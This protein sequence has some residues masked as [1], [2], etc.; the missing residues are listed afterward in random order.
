[1][2][3]T[4]YTAY[5]KA[6]LSAQE[7][8][9]G[10][11]TEISEEWFVRV[12]FGDE[13]DKALAATGL[14]ARNA[15]HPTYD[16]L[17]VATRVPTREDNGII[18]SFEIKY[19]IINVDADTYRLIH[20]EYGTHELQEDLVRNLGTGKV[21]KDA[22]GKP[23][24]Q[25]MQVSK[26]YPFI[27]ITKKQGNVDR[28]TVITTSGSINNAKVTVAG[29][30]IPKWCGKIR[31]QAVEQEN[32]PTYNWEISYEVL[33]R[34]QYLTNYVDFAD[35]LQTPAAPGNE[36]G[37]MEGIVNQGFYKYVTGGTGLA[38][39]TEQVEKAD[40]S[41][42]ERP[43]A[44]PA[45]LDENGEQLAEGADPMSILLQIHPD[46]NWSGLGLNEV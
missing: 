23:F 4:L 1:M 36:I 24:S 40:G 9:D 22:N 2:G 39:I 37:W 6:Q 32:E 15:V 33:V 8:P 7:D 21:L 43:S 17:R 5:K 10:N 41:T 29:V 38:R 46:K 25:T 11:I 35:V 18:F 45:L 19:K 31:I 14:P 42:E 26:S 20:I 44:T 3:S 30:T 13:V 12:A 28:E 34:Y 16:Y 27:K